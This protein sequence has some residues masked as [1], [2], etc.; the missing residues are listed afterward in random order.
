MTASTS[1]PK[2]IKRIY[3]AGPMRGLPNY[4]FPAFH[5]AAKRLRADGYIVKSPAE[6]DTEQDGCK[7]DGSDV[8]LRDLSHYMARDLPEICR[9][10]AV[11]LLPGWEESEGVSIEVAL[12]RNLNKPL[13]AFEK[14]EET[15]RCMLWPVAQVAAAVPD[16]AKVESPEVRMTDPVTGGQKGVK[17]ARFDLIPAWALEEIARVYG[18]GAQKYTDDNWRK[19]YP[20]RLSIGAMLRHISLWRQRN[21]LDAETRL[22]HLAHAAWHCLTLMTFECEGLGTD[23]REQGGWKNDSATNEA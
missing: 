10:D 1:I 17:L 3:L 22:H 4:N 2:P 9:C 20:W 8:I 21:S 6:M 15:G 13:W 11:V 16:P 14:E 5:D 12:A 18:R 23:D 19:G 7:S